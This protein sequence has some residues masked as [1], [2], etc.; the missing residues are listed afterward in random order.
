MNLPN[1]L[2]VSRMIIAPIFL[3]TLML[4]KLPHNYLLSIVI[5]AIAAVTDALDGNLARKNNQITVFGKLLD[6]VADKMLTTA[7][8]LAFLKL[9]LCDVFSIMLILTREFA[10]TSIRLIAS[11]QGIV[12]PANTWGKIK[13]I[14]QMVTI[15]LVMLMGELHYCANTYGFMNFSFDTMQIISY[16]LVWITVVLTVVSG[17]IYFVQAKKRI[18]FSK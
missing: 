16:I 9:G 8:Y 13:T 12:I 14:S 15:V 2:T 1:K 5:F 18:D 11:A 10:V 6:P 7:A 4:D 3:L 17:I